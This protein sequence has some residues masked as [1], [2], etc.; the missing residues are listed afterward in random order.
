M[1]DLLDNCRFTA[2]STG[3]AD[4]SDGTADPSFQNLEDAGAV[5]GRMYPYKAQNATGTE[6][7]FGRGTALETSGG[8]VLERTEIEKSS[9][10]GA[11]VNF[12]VQP[13]VIITAG[14]LEV[15]GEAATVSSAQGRTYGSVPSF[16]RTA[17]KT[18]VD[19]GEGHLYA[20]V[21]SEPSAVSIATY[22]KGASLKAVG[23]AIGNLTGGGGLAAAF[24]GVGD[25]YLNSAR[26][27]GTT[28]RY[29]GRTVSG[30]RVF[31]AIINPS[32]DQGF[33]QNAD[34]SVTISL[35]GK[36]GSAPANAT[37]GTLLG[38][39]T[40]TDINVNIPRSV[41][42]G[43]TN[44][45]TAWDHIWIH[46]LGDGTNNIAVG[47]LDFLEADQSTGSIEPEAFSITVAGGT[48]WYDAVAPCTGHFIAH[49]KT[50][51]ELVT[52]L[53]I[54]NPTPSNGTQR[55]VFSRPIY[56]QQGD[57]IEASAEMEVTTA[58]APGGSNVGVWSHIILT[59]D[60][61]GVVP[62]DSN[63]KITALNG[64]NCTPEMHHDTHAHSGTLIAPATGLFYVNFV[65]YAANSSATGN[66]T[67]EQGYG[68]LSVKRTRGH[69]G[70]LV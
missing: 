10:S 42:A 12:T 68:H 34:P 59:P 49:A 16:I 47:E 66:I 11:A 26:N 25:T 14:C 17:G 43:A 48:E 58:E 18:D 65:A 37:D 8:W 62:Q 24:N 36:T 27:S 13:K 57:L 54:S 52:A 20:N 23:S 2:G 31:C 9:N 41:V 32:T 38:S 29:I 19:D 30:R 53:P 69:I 67:V 64:R 15:A 61:G 44:I 22:T 63:Y 7:E 50:M 70:S 39:E 35:Y 60:P 51:T 3:T 46:V 56:L 33:I 45:A 21:D 5:D 40:F 55:V 1:A 6:W 28:P 4:F